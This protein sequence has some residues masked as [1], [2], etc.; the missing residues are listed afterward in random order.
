MLYL[1]GILEKKTVIETKLCSCILGVGQ[2]RKFLTRMHICLSA[3]FFKNMHTII[4]QIS[5]RYF[6]KCF[7]KSYRICFLLS[8]K[9]KGEQGGNGITKHKQAPPLYVYCRVHG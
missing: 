3:T 5:K 2:S 6:K 7:Y 4:K 8:P 1:L 9:V